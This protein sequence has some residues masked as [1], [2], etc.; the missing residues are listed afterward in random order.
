MNTA[1]IALGSNIAEREDFLKS[2]IDMLEEHS[3]IQVT[4]KSS[5]YETAPVGYTDQSDFLNMVVE[6][7][8]SLQPLQMLDHCQSIEAE[9]GRERLVKWG[10]R[11]IDLDILLYNHENMEAERLVI[12]HPHMHERAFVMVPLA[13][14]APEVI[15]PQINLSVEE[16]LRGLPAEEVESMRIWGKI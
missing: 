11:T 10:P 2:A 5:V 6:V 1:Y 7:T 3:E 14:L 16:I 13:E 4:E 15:L 12:P 8:T 9:L